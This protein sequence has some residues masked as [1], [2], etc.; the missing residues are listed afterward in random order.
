[1]A[2]LLAAHCKRTCYSRGEAIVTT[3]L[4]TRVSSA[5]GD[6]AAAAARLAS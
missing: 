6:G 2:P 5:A 4:P 3:S 1:M